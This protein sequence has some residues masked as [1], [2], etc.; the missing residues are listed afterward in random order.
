[1][2]EPLYREATDNEPTDEYGQPF[3]CKLVELV[4][5]QHALDGTLCDV[6]CEA[7]VRGD[8]YC[9]VPVTDDR[10]TRVEWEATI[11][12]EFIMDMHAMALA[13]ALECGTTY[14]V[15]RLREWQDRFDAAVKENNVSDPCNYREK[16]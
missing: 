4:P 3:K 11:D 16:T 2:N 1:M 8:G 13:W 15:Q 10:L 7:Y 6:Q 5:C 14:D 12:K 9:E